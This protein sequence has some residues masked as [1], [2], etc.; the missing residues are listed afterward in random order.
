MSKHTPGPWEY[1]GMGNGGWAV[2]DRRNHA[3]IAVIPATIL[4]DSPAERLYNARLIAEAPALLAL[5]E[6][7]A[8][9]FAD[10]G[11]PLGIDAR[12]IIRRA[13]GQDTDQA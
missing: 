7:I 4:P 8:A 10:T 12:A 5:A 9:H 11:S 2:R 13:R 6:R 1:V 3:T